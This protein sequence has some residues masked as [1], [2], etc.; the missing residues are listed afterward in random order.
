MRNLISVDG[1]V[2]Q[3]QILRFAQNDNMTVSE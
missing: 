1:A 2:K 3:S